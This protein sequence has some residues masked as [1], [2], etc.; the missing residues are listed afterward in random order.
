MK[1][2]Q[3]PS[4]ANDSAPTVSPISSISGL[5]PATEASLTEA[6]VTSAEHLRALGADQAYRMLLAKG[7]RPHFIMY[8]ALHMAL[9][10]R[11]WNDCKGKEKDGFRKRFDAIL[12]EPNDRPSGELQKFLYDMGLA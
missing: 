11:P 8:Y 9:Q 2:R 5:G 1:P 6:G 12:A 10:G 3:K 4:M 7:S